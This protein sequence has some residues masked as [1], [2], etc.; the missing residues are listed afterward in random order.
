MNKALWNSILEFLPLN[1]YPNLPC[2]FCHQETLNFDEDTIVSKPVSKHYEKVASR[3]YQLIKDERR[4]EL[5]ES[6][7]AIK[8]MWNEHPLWGILGAVGAILIEASKPNYNFEKFTAFMTCSNCYD[9]VAVTGLMQRHIT[10]TETENEEPSLYKIDHFSTPI[11]MFNLDEHI[12]PAIQFELFA[13]FRYFHIDTNSS[14]N[15]LRRAIECFCKTIGDENK[16]LYNNINLLAN[17]YPLESEL[18]HT[19]RILGNKG[20]HSDNTVDINED[21]LI[22]AFDI[23][24]E[25]LAVFR[26][27]HKLTTLKESQQQLLEKFDKKYIENTLKHEESAS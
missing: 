15:K 24:E 7:Q 17:S 2:P 20:S 23:F 6:G 14:A 16:N 9:H 25:V 26:K 13:A 8:E 3:H 19:L 21:D 1:E 10:K 11:S 27:R 5:K 22:K 4:K 18:L 12:P